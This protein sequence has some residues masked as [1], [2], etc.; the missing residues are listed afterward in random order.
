M[1][2]MFISD[3]ILPVIM[4]VGGAIMTKHCPKHINTVVGYRTR[5]SMKNMDTWKFAHNY[6]G[7]LWLK[8]GCITIIPS[9]LVLVLFCHS[10]EDTIAMM[11][12]ALI[13]IQ[14]VILIISVCLTERALKMHFN[15]DGTRKANR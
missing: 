7:K 8:L 13:I 10:N 11:S 9:A 14:F 12:K 3:I 2:L 6:C 1:G 15:N 4:I 5:R